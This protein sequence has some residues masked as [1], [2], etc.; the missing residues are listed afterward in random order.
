MPS[1]DLSRVEFGGDGDPLI[2]Q[3]DR[4]HIACILRVGDCLEHEDGTGETTKHIPCG[5]EKAI[6]NGTITKG[7]SFVSATQDERVEVD[8]E[9]Y[10]ADEFQDSRESNSQSTHL[11]CTLFD[12]LECLSTARSYLQRAPSKLLLLLLH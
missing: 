12:P 2:R 1:N 5:R 10:E 11:E 4:D 8:K 6:S 3:D 9:G 7:E